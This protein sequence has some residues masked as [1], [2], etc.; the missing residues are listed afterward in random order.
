MMKVATSHM[1][2]IFE[3]SP[4]LLPWKPKG[5]LNDKVK[6][7]CMSGRGGQAGV[8]RFYE[9]SKGV[10]KRTVTSSATPSPK[11]AKKEEAAESD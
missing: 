2:A 11:K 9:E 1:A 8:A 3:A 10:K 4:E 7:F 6:Q 5:R